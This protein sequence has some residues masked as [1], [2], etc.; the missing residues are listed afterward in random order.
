MSKKFY[1]DYLLAASSLVSLGRLNSASR[2]GEE[3]CLFSGLNPCGLRALELHEDE[4]RV[5]KLE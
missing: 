2:V 3:W 5:F 1:K 4:V